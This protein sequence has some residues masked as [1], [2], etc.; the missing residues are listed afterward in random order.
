MSD[1]H[2]HR[3]RDDEH[4][5]E[6]DDD[7]QHISPFVRVA[8]R[9]SYAMGTWQN[10]VV[11]IILVGTWF[12]LGPYLAHHSVLPAWFTSNNFNFPLNTVT[13]IAELYIGFLVGASTNRTERHNRNQADRM[14]ALEQLIHTELK[15]NTA[16]TDNAQTIAEQV[17]AQVPLLERTHADVA[18]L[19]SAMSPAPAA[20]T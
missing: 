12:A 7:E 13:T 1:H 11:W 18:R 8:D 20:A 10:I 17:Q 9:V 6:R 3:E 5:E 16:I 19:L 15:R 14:E 4:G 2:D